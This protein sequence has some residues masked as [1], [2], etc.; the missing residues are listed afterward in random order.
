MFEVRQTADFQR[1]LDN[2]RDSRAQKAIVARTRRMG[3]GNFGDVKR[4]AGSVSEIRIDYGPGYRLYFMRQGATVVLLL[5]GG[6]KHSQKK[7]I[8]AAQAMA[9]E[10]RGTK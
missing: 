8:E 6:D 10:F 9:E 5:M 3:L 1:W 7:D 4:V 2:L